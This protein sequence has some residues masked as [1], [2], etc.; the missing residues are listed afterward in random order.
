MRREPGRRVQRVVQRGASVIAMALLG[1]APSGQ[2]V[3]RVQVEQ[4]DE[5]AWV[6]SHSSDMWSEHVD[7]WVDVVVDEQGR[8]A[9]Q[10][11]GFQLDEQIADLEAAVHSAWPPDPRP[12]PFF[13]DW[14]DLGDFDVHLQGLGR[15]PHATV[16]EIGRS[17]EDRPI[18]AIRIAAYNAPPD[19]PEILVTGLMHAREWVSGASAMYIADRLV[20]GYLHD[21]SVGRVLAQYN[22][23]VVPVVNPDGYRHT[24]TTDRLWRKNRAVFEDAVGVDLNR[25][26]GEAWGLN[27]GSSPDPGHQNYRGPEAFSEPET[28]AL[29]QLVRDTSTFA[30]HLDLHCTGQLVLYP[31]AHT[32]EASAEERRLADAASR[33][34]AEMDAAHGLTYDDGMFHT[35]LYAGSGVG[36]DWTHASGLDSYLFE[37]RDRGRYGFLLPAEQLRPTAEEAWAGF[38]T[39]TVE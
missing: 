29:Q 15:E 17:V 36:I 13:D 4:P 1:C 6:L 19:R 20:Q 26:W 38:V 37:L 10:A 34:V 14:R 5:L 31:W 33:A 18:W 25:N 32:E 39:L 8:H 12:G 3:V 23:V 24:W 11:S 21:A 2:S 16:W 22:V 28:T 9:L 35:R 7:G 27:R 30:M